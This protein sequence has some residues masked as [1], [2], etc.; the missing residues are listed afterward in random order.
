MFL[1]LPCHTY[2]TASDRKNLGYNG[3]EFTPTSPKIPSQFLQL[4][5]A[6]LQY[7][8]ASTM[9]MKEYKPFKR[10]E[11]KG[12]QFL[13]DQSKLCV[14]VF[15]VLNGIVIGLKLPLGMEPSSMRVDLKM[16]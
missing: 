6:V 2:W 7:Y 8:S 15:K 16:K 10:S 11:Q 9:P 5:L 1:E 12:N 3:T 14:F 4:D 13:H